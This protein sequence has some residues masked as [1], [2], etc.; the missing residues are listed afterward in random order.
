MTGSP[1]SA[2]VAAARTYNQRGVITPIPNEV[3]LGLTRCTRIT[4][5]SGSL[6]PVFTVFRWGFSKASTKKDD[7]ISTLFNPNNPGALG[8]CAKLLSNRVLCRVRRGEVQHPKLILSGAWS[9]VE[10]RRCPRR[11]RL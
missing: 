5:R 11:T 3:S 8:S 2:G 4:E 6:A 7:L 10:S 1:Y 9:K